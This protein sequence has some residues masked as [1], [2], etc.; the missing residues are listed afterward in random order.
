MLTTGAWG[1]GFLTLA[2]PAA[3][4]ARASIWAPFCWGLWGEGSKEALAVWPL[5]ALPRELQEKKK[6]NFTASRAHDLIIE[7]KLPPGPSGCRAFSF[8]TQEQQL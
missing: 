2:G 7:K 6:K 3:G 8:I 1:G 5:T 4:V